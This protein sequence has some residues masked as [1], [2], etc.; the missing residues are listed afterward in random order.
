M[1]KYKVSKKV[2]NEIMKKFLTAVKY[3]LIA[4]GLATIL[5]AI[6]IWLFTYT[7]L[8]TAGLSSLALVVFVTVTVLVYLEVW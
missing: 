8:V 7:N 4:A 1:K 6:V 5:N 2:M 3:G